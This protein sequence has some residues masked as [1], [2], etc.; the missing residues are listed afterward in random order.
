MVLIILI[1]CWV[2]HLFAA[3]ITSVFREVSKRPQDDAKAASMA[4]VVQAGVGKGLLTVIKTAEKTAMAATGVVRTEGDGERERAV[5][6]IH[7]LSLLFHCLSVPKPPMPMPF[8]TG[9]VERAR[10][11][12]KKI[13]STALFQ[14]TIMSVIG[15][16]AEPELQYH[17]LPLSL[18][19][20]G[21]AHSAVS[22][23]A[24]TNAGRRPFLSHFVSLLSLRH[25]SLLSLQPFPS[26]CRACRFSWSCQCSTWSSCRSSTTR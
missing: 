4:K 5:T 16:R 21:G 23:C 15:E 19:M 11:F 14:N 18:F 12:W 2:V 24:T 22:V 3:V 25:L 10:T 6:N 9:V 7:C 8:R 1:C 20:D 17:S 26:Y 13:I